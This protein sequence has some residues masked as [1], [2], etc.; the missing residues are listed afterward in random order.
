MVSEKR[1]PSE[2]SSVSL[3][4]SKAANLYKDAYSLYESYEKKLS[5]SLNKINKFMKDE[6][7]G[8]VR[9]LRA[10]SLFIGRKTDH[11]EPLKSAILFK[12][13]FVNYNLPIMDKY[14]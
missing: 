7:I 4:V 3:A 11:D 8:K 6:E 13:Q 1:L 5:Q 9:K 10:A 12:D 2:L 14:R